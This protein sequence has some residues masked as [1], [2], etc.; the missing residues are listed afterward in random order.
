MN[1]TNTWRV[2]RK[3]VYV[4]APVARFLDTNVRLA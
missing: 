1:I 3:F 4:V 2:D